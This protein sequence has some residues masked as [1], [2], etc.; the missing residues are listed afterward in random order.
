ML[1][2]TFNCNSIRARLPIVLDWLAAA[3]PDVLALQETKV[4]DRDFPLLEIEAAGYKAVFRGEKSYNGVAMLLRHEPD[5][6]SFGLQDG[7]EGASETRLCHIKYEGIQVLNT[8]VPQGQ[9]FDSP[10]FPF[11][12]EWLARL[13]RYFEAHVD[14]DR[15]ELV[16]VGDLNV[17]PLPIDVWDHKRIWPHVVHCQQTT[18]ALDAITSRGLVDVFRK[19]LPEPDRY[20]FWDY[21]FPSSLEQNR[22]WRIDHVWATPPL[23]ARSTEVV[24]DVAARRL[25]KPSDHTFVAAR[26]VPRAAGVSSSTRAARRARSI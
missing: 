7:D 4:V 1:I 8:Y 3:S 16:W 24:V 12:L 5:E 20:T 19:H 22:G 15:D 25:P 17:A 14:P 23:A 11:K 21:R 13:A 2:A 18:D 9:A 26:F 6:V 10:K